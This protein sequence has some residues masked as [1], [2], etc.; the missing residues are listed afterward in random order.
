M[1]ND[2]VR[3]QRYAHCASHTCQSAAGACTYNY[4]IELCVNS[5]LAKYYMQGQHIVTD[6]QYNNGPKDTPIKHKLNSKN[7]ELVG[8][9]VE[10]RLAP[11]TDVL[12][13][14]QQQR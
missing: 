3:V 1:V 14:Y 10:G 12:H 2:H 5:Q 4:K 6:E 7:K 13:P 11:K 8:N 9:M